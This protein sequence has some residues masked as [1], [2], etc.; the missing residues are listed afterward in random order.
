MNKFYDI[1]NCGK[2]SFIGYLSGDKVTC[3]IEAS[4]DGIEWKKIGPTLSHQFIF[5]CEITKDK[6]FKRFYNFI[7]NLF[8]KRKK[9]YLRMVI[10]EKDKNK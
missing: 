6:W 1:D 8:K 3:E 9:H 4:T 10:I 5:D 2:F 7:R